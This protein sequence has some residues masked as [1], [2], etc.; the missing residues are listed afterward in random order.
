MATEADL[1]SALREIHASGVRTTTAAMVA[2][3]LW[4]TGRCHNANGQVFHLSAGIAGRMLR[5]CRAVYET[6]PRRWE[7]IPEYLDKA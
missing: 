2:E 3:R 4:P 1:M 5:R 6:Q 7:I